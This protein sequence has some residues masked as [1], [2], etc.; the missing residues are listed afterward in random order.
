MNKKLS[1]MCISILLIFIFC[2][3]QNKNQIS[4]SSVSLDGNT[5]SYGMTKTDV[6]KILGNGEQSNISLSPNAIEYNKAIKIIYRKEKICCMEITDKNIISYN[7]IKIGDSTKDI[8]NKYQYEINFENRY[9]IAFSSGKEVN[10]NDPNS[11]KLVDQWITYVTDNDILTKI[12][13]YDS[14]FANTMG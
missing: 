10:A 7:N 11:V 3:C 8:L 6:E 1:T 13:I 9:M 14:Q 12:Q 4:P 5:I 2:G